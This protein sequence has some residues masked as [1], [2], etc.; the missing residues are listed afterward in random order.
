MDVAAWLRGLGLQQY[1]PIFRDNDIDGAVLPSLT[2]EDLT[3]LGIASVGH[4][5]LLAAIASLNARGK[6]PAIAPVPD[7]L[8]AAE[9]ERRQLTV[10]FCDLVGST[11]LSARLDPEDL[12]EVIGAYHRCVANVV[13]GFDGFVSRYMGDGVLIYF[14]YPQA[15]EDDSERGVRAGLAVIEA[16]D[17]L[18]VK[19]GKL[20]TR[21]GIST[22]LA[23]VGD[24]IGE[25]SAQEH[26]RK[27]NSDR[28]GAR[29]RIGARYYRTGSEQK[30]P[31]RHHRAATPV[32][33]K[34]P[35]GGGRPRTVWR[36]QVM[37]AW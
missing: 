35:T 9:A 11:A 26:K 28:C 3:G 18:D 19:T 7:G 8:S 20:Q 29:S 27:R 34:R 14:G 1:E 23:V 33:T 15:H 30:V 22:G 10:V 37:T 17:R 12:R 16:I 6:Q 2:A 25:G 36:R 4:R 24:L 32:G 5:R 13:A 21:V 31:D